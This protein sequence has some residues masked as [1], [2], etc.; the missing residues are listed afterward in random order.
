MTTSNP[1][2]PIA[3]AREDSGSTDGDIGRWGAAA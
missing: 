3:A 2:V 1:D